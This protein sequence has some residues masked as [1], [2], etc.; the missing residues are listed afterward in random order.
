MTRRSPRILFIIKKSTNSYGCR[1]VYSYGQGPSGLLNSVKFVVEMLNDSGVEAKCVQVTDNNDIDREV[2]RYKPTQV[3]I[4]ALWVVPEKFIIL[5]RL[6]P[7][8]KWVVRTHSE[9]PFLAQEGSSIGWI[10]KYVRLDNVFVAANSE[11]AFKDV[12]T[13]V[14]SA[15]PFWTDR[16]VDEKVLYLPN[17]YPTR[18]RG[19]DLKSQTSC[20]QVGCFGAIRPL[21]NQLIQAVA[22]IEYA[23]ITGQKTCFHVNASRLEAG[24]DGALKNLRALFAGSPRHE[25]I[26]HKWMSHDHFL[27][28]LSQMDL[29]LCV[30]FS[31]SFCIVAADSIVA[32]VPLVG[33]SEIA[34]LGKASQ[35][36]AT[37]TNDIVR[38]ISTALDWKLQP[39]LKIINRLRLRHFSY[40]SRNIWLEFSH[41]N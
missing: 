30:S 38:K 37:S 4:E 39:L 41:H 28:M 19:S 21:K 10:L 29:S 11:R 31:E 15:N 24:G 40:R 6:H 35:A 25:L 3:M 13:I 34:F 22:A 16:Q 1:S 20:L 33:S 2:S 18:F 17:F 23:D 5:R 8:V 27:F 9:I 7:H 36:E 26:E 12:Q 14:R 32:G